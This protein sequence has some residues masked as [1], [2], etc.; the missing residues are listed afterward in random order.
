MDHL[1]L[2]SEENGNSYN[3]IK[4]IK[5]IIKVWLLLCINI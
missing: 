1:K 2:K 5:Y 3:T 4:N